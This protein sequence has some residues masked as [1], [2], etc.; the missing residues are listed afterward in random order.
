MAGGAAGPSLS[1]RLSQPQPPEQ[2]SPVSVSN[3]RPINVHRSRRL[4]LRT[5][6]QGTGPS[7]R[8]VV[9]ELP[10]CTCTRARTHGRAALLRV[11]SHRW[12]QAAQ[13]AV[14]PRPATWPAAHGSPA[15][16]RAAVH[17]SGAVSRSPAWSFPLWAEARPVG[18]MARAGVTG[19]L[20]HPHRGEAPEPCRA[21]S[22]ACRFHGDGFARAA[23]S[24]LCRLPRSLEAGTPSSLSSPRP[25]R[26][27]P[28]TPLTHASRDPA[29][30]T[31]V[32]RGPH[33]LLAVQPRTQT[34]PPSPLIGDRPGPAPGP[35]RAPSRRLP[36]V[37]SPRCPLSHPHGVRTGGPGRNRES[38]YEDPGCLVTLPPLHDT[39]GC[40]VWRNQ[41][42]FVL[43]DSLQ[44]ARA[45][46]V[47]LS[48]PSQTQAAP[49]PC[50][51][52]GPDKRARPPSRP[53][54]G[55]RG[56]AA[57]LLPG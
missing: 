22:R 32:L 19:A 43:R 38:T 2:S 14:P 51:T 4:S 53:C 25:G 34:S 12:C 13:T 49:P 23:A 47:C 21:P 15:P 55:G 5:W 26:A 37:P 57:L 7:V 16:G 39:P 41:A 29:A 56:T 10:L 50:W 46:I 17:R 36:M 31:T 27:G 54:L 44:L 48:L 30:T 3:Y 6:P 8:R 42:L 20:S 1:P 45:P 28:G 40:P 24:V 35:G 9:P 52:V 11:L 33:L 18:G